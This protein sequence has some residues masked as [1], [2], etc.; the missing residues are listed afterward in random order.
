[1]LPAGGGG[2]APGGRS[3]TTTSTASPTNTP[4]PAAQRNAVVQPGPWSRAASGTA[5]STCPS[6][7]TR[8][9]SCVIT[10]T[11]RGGNQAVTTE[12]TLMNVSA[13]PVPIS[14][15]AVT[16][17]GS[18]V[19]SASTSWPVAIVNAPTATSVRPPNRSSSSPTGT[20]SAA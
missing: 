10:G 1:M 3:R 16:A 4:S 17:S 9:V 11:R 7:P 20:C 6:C 5:D 12:R 2:G 14:T 8:P 19:A 15:R 18:V 13:S